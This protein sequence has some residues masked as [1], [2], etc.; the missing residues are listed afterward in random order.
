MPQKGVDA[1]KAGVDEDVEYQTFLSHPRCCHGRY[2]VQRMQGAASDSW[3]YAPFL[4]DA[5][6]HHRSQF[7]H[8][9]VWS[10]AAVAQFTTTLTDK[11]HQ[12][13]HHFIRDYAPR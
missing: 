8:K 5:F 2:A 9:P 6:E 10:D 1:D 12:Q 11:Q 13:Q 3:L 7:F 4:L